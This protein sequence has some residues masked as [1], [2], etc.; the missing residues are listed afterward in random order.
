MENQVVAISRSLF[1]LNGPQHDP[2]T[3]REKIAHLEAKLLKMPQAEAPLTH[4][5]APGIYAREIFIPK[6]ALAIGHVHKTE[7]IGIMSQGEMAMVT[8][9]GGVKIIKAPFTVVAPPGTK[10]V[11]YALEDSVFIAVHHNPDN[12]VELDM[13]EKRF[14][15]K[16]HDDVV[17]LRAELSK[18]VEAI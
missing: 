6:G 16:T 11:V 17:L 5:F 10:R 4:H 15:A 7:H 14:I 3:I 2:L 1:S 13:L 9:D 12:E 8:E 18:L